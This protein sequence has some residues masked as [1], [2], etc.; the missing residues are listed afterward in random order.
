[1]FGALIDALASLDRFADP[2]AWVVV[3]AFVGGAL[4]ER[5]D[6]EA[7]RYLTVGAWVAFALFWLS[8]VYHFAFVQ[9]S[10]IEGLGTLVAV[11]ASLYTGYLLYRGRDS[12]FV[13]SRA[14]AGMGLVFMPFQT[15]PFLRE[16]LIE[17]VA[18]QTKF[19]MGLLGYHP[20]LVSGA[21]VPGADHYAY[22]NTFH[23]L[24]ENFRGAGQN[25][26]VFYTIKIACTGIGSMAIFGGLIAAVRAPLRRKARALSLSIPIIYVLNLVRNVF[27]GLSFG[28]MKMQFFAGAVS[29]LFA[30]D[31]Q[32]EP[33]KV[34]YYLA[35]RIV[36]Q[37]ASVVVL[38][39]I[40]WLVV[41]ELPEVLTIVEDVLFVFTGSEYDLRR[42]LDLPADPSYSNN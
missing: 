29:T 12:L 17:T 19:L 18:L 21:L 38:V 10:I 25:Y 28:E 40:T 1:M 22:Q 6:R 13:L 20:D 3:A 35:D 37:S 30:F 4:L 34:S 41:R 39:A 2:L 26:E 27:I 7:G 24:H 14:I 16:W 33:A 32:A 23:F 42:A 8:L 5:Y 11:P 15:I 31:L 9:K 36:S